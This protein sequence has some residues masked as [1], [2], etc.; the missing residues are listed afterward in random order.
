MPSEKKHK[1]INKLLSGFVQIHIL[2]HAS[3]GELYGSWLIEHLKTH[4]YN[5]SP[6]TLYPML[7]RMV[8][9][10]LLTASEHNIE[11]HIRKI[12]RT[13]SLGD[14][15]LKEANDKIRELTTHHLD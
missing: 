5:L 7:K 15:A 9:D 10:D 2:R 8:N 4:G 13:T 1:I 3:R 11:G 12:Y 14:E 6:G